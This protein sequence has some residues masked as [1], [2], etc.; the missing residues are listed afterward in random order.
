MYLRSGSIKR[1]DVNSAVMNDSA[2]PDKK[3][4][5]TDALSGNT[6]NSL[7]TPARRAAYL[8]LP[9]IYLS[10][11]AVTRGSDKRQAERNREIKLPPIGQKLKLAP[12]S[13]SI[14]CSSNDMKLE[15]CQGQLR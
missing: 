12:A 5:F 7:M 4:K 11:S 3:S 6:L 15:K 8:S 1:R 13:S 10:F 14:S 2:T 9:P